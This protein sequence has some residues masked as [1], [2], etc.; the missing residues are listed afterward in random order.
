MRKR[1]L[2]CRRYAFVRPDVRPSV[3]PSVTLVNCIQTAEDI[4]TLLSRPGSPII[5]VFLTPTTGTNTR[6]N[7]FSMGAKY[8]GCVKIFAIFD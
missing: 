6:G 4:V 7:P 8:R 5:L 3:C 1:S 2:C